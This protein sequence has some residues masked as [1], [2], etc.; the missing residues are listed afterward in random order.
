MEQLFTPGL[1]EGC[2]NGVMRRHLLTELKAA[3]IPGKE[4]L[5][6][7]GDIK[8]ADEIFLTNAINGIR[9]V[10][11]FRD[12]IYTNIQMTDLEIYQTILPKTS[13]TVYQ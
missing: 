13:F 6:L 2:V 1:E 8:N 5:L 12:K 11:Q 7:S 4:M 9:W 3:G 10:R